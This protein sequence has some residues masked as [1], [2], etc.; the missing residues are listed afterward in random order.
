MLWMRTSFN[1]M[2]LL[3]GRASYCSL[4][5]ARCALPE[6]YAL[7]L[8]SS[9]SK[10][11]VSNSLPNQAPGDASSQI[12]MVNME[13]PGTTSPS[14][15]IG[16]DNAGSS[17]S[18]KR[19]AINVKTL[20]SKLE[21]QMGDDPA[22]DMVETSSSHFGD[23]DKVDNDE[24]RK[25]LERL[26]IATIYSLVEKVRSST[27]LCITWWENILMYWLSSICQLQIPTAAGGH[28][29]MLFLTNT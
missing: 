1:S 22:L 12:A 27:A 10:T 14:A 5:L 26:Q 25:E 23:D 4:S 9:S 24:F 16:D 7:V 17:P 3:S 18:L 8:R 15:V 19:S 6:S 21:H 11:P 29:N 28:V 13:F 20:S 2:H